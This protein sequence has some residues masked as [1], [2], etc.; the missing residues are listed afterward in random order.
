MIQIFKKKS[1]KI[2]FIT[3][4]LWW[5]ENFKNMVVPA[6]TK[7]PDWYTPENTQLPILKR[8]RQEW[9]KNKQGVGIPAGPRNTVNKCPAFIDSF[10]NTWLILAPCDIVID[11]KTNEQWSWTSAIPNFGLKQHSSVE[12]AGF[13]QFKNKQNLKFVYPYHI[14]TVTEA[15]DMMILPASWHT[16]YEEMGNMEILTGKVTCTP[17][18]SIPL[19]LNT[20]VTTDNTLITIKQGTVLA[21]MHFYSPVELEVEYCKDESF[22]WSGLFDR[23]TNYRQECKKHNGE[24]I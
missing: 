16:N 10:T 22:V 2:K 19:N 11:I 14:K 15:V 24:N 13:G 21:Q 23:T 3:P 17:T 5:V 20:L 6:K 1:K 9:N 4:S 7:M 18:F 8:I 12:L